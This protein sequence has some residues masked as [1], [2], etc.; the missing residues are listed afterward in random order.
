MM[1]I[2]LGIPI[3]VVSVDILRTS[4]SLITKEGSIVTF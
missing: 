2:S 4:T 1:H 3:K